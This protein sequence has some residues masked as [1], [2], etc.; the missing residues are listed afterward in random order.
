MSK[1]FLQPFQP[2]DFGEFLNYAREEGHN[3]EIATCA[4]SVF[5][6]G[7]WETVLGG[8]RERLKD[9]EGIVSIHGPF[10]D[11]HLTSRDNRI[12]AVSRERI[13]Q[14]LTAARTL[15]A[16]F[17][18]FH[19]GYNP[20][21][22]HESY[23]SNWIE[24]TAACWKSV[25]DRFPLTILIENVWEPS[26]DNFRRLIDTAGSPN[27]KICFDTGHANVFSEVDIDEWF[28]TLRDDIAYIHVNDNYGE[29]DSEN[30]PGQGNIDWPKFSRLIRKYGIEPYIVL[31]VGSLANTR[32]AIAYM[33]ENRIYPFD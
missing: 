1:I 7:D 13:E 12:V 11:L 6:D 18:V 23:R 25:I 15:N 27:L 4:S 33:S 24:K 28:E 31:E 10:M 5:L 29:A 26:P 3:L 9:F 21:I 32:A 22:R 14:G 30:I 2:E 17:A 8:Y 19:G 16:R 20:L